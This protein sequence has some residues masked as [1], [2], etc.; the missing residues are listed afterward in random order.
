MR[1]LLAF[2]VW[3]FL[4][5]GVIGAAYGLVG[6]DAAMLTFVCLFAV[7]VGTVVMP[8][9]FLLPEPPVASGPPPRASRLTV[10][11]ILLI[12]AWA[13]FFMFPLIPTVAALGAL[14]RLLRGE[15]GPPDIPLLAIGAAIPLIIVVLAGATLIRHRRLVIRGQTA[16]GRVTEFVKGG[17]RYTFQVASGVAHLGQGTAQSFRIKVGATINVFYDP[18]NPKS[19]VASCASFFEPIPPRTSR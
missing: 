6:P 1:S 13:L 2:G 17:F 9:S 14:R 19:S 16:A 11:A 12:P 15:A 3:L 10:R 7:G 4:L 5:S 8:L 18:D